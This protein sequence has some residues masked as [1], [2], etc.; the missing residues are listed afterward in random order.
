MKGANA[1]VIL[2][3]GEGGFSEGFYAVEDLKRL[4]RGYTGGIWRNRIDGIAPVFKD[5]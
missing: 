1:R 2:M 3:A 4:T 5:K